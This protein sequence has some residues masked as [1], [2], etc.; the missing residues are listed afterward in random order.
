VRPAAALAGLLAVVLGITGCLNLGPEYQRPAD[1]V[2]PPAEFQQGMAPG[3]TIVYDAKWWQ[4]FN[5]PELDQYM[6]AVLA[7]NW[8]IARTADRVMELRALA[9]Q[10]R[11]DRYPQVDIDWLNRKDV[12]K[13]PSPGGGRERTTSSTYDLALP[14]FFELDLWGRLARAEEAVR[15]E[16]LRAEENR[17]VV[18][19]T[20]VAEALS[21]YFEIESIE[22]GLAI[23]YQLIDNFKNNLRLVGRRYERGLASALDVRQARRILAEAE[24]AIPNLRRDLGARQ[25]QLAVLM[26]RYP[27]AGPPRTH[28]DDYYERLPE[29]PPGLPSDLLLRRPDIRSAEA[30]L[31]ALNA[32]VAEALASRFPRI[33][34]TGSFGYQST[35]LDQLLR[36]DSEL[37]T[38]ANGIT[39]P[40]FDAGRLEEGQRAAEAR[41]RQGVADY[42]QAVLTA[43]AEVEDALLARREQLVRR[44]R[45]VIFLDEAR[46]TQTVAEK[47]YGRG[48]T[49][50][51]DVLD[52]QRVRFLA[53][54]DLVEADLALYINR[55]NLYL[56]LGGDWADPGQVPYE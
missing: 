55:I 46:Q 21:L 36:S 2:A 45:V 26:G 38:F 33:T 52:A 5:D 47:R 20:V 39:Q 12:R 49:P 10:A 56:A 15:A 6:E 31:I 40:L 43:F 3:E 53:E 13:L 1:V 42:A 29:V 48:L 9:G 14:L 22:R 51:L 37:W 24:A 35:H 11:A 4:I 19:Q 32:R 8:D 30:R 17:R 34:L 7:N 50:Y 25:H 41:Y 54:Q 28:P 27:A 16:L 18:A 23:S 44:E